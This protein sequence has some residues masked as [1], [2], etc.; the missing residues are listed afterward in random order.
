MRFQID[1]EHED[2]WKLILAIGEL[3][4]RPSNN[5]DVEHFCKVQSERLNKLWDAYGVMEGLD[6]DVGARMVSA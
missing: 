6:S 4:K 1:F 2:L 5:A 3:E